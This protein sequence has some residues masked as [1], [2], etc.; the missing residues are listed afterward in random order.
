VAI[1]GTPTNE[2]RLVTLP[3]WALWREPTRVQALVVA[4]SAGAALLSAAAFVQSTITA[5]DLLRFGLL[6]M[7][8]VAY[9]EVSRQ[10]EVRRRLFAPPDSSHVDMSSVWILAGALILPAGLAALIVPIAYAYLWVRSWRSLDGVHAYRVT[11]TCATMTITCLAAWA[12]AHV[13]PLPGGGVAHLLV[14]IVLAA[15]TYRVVN[16]ALVVLAIALTIGVHERSTVT[17]TWH[18]NAVEFATF[19]MGAATAVLVVQVP[20]LA[21][22]VLPA[23]FLLQHRALLTQLVEAAT[24][25]MKT[26]LLNAAAWRQLADREL[27]RAARQHTATAVLVID[28]DHFK[29][30]NDTYGHL[31]GDEALRAVGAA[32]GDVLR[33][34]DAVGRFGGEEF[35]AL[36]PGVDAATAVV[37][38]ERVRERIESLPIRVERRTGAAATIAVTA[39]VGVAAAVGAADLDG[40]LRAADEALYAAKA[41]GRNVVRSAY[42]P[43]RT[44]ESESPNPGRVRALSGRADYRG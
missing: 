39:S 42:V 20:P 11:Y 26:D 34:Y 18:H 3:S 1:H 8:S 24:I 14:A 32:L 10:V 17:G 15:V 9:L 25:D 19:T 6:A 28:M 7:L 5:S 41:A 38:G 40:L 4:V 12:V 30:L 2:S 35:A 21:L 23:V 13:G 37:V 27:D 22:L 44:P 43:D 29:R 31:A 33:G 36:L 16:Q